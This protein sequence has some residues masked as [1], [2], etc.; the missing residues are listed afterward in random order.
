MGYEGR[1]DWLPVGGPL[2]VLVMSLW[3]TSIVN[4]S[5]ASIA[6]LRFRTGEPL[7]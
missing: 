3:S 5:A 6:V 1:A 2:T 7:M 4:R